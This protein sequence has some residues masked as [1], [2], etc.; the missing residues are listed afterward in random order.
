MAKPKGK[1]VKH[2]D[3]EEWEWNEGSDSAAPKLTGGYV[4]PDSE[5]DPTSV[6]TGDLKSA[7]EKVAEAAGS[8]GLTLAGEPEPEPE[9]KAEPKKVTTTTAKPLV[10][11]K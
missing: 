10:S 3:V 7:S 9:E 11:K 6:D 2:G 5:F 8:K 4:V 1:Y